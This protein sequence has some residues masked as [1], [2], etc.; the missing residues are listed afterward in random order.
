MYTQARVYSSYSSRVE[1]EWVV[2][3]WLLV[4]DGLSGPRRAVDIEAPVRYVSPFLVFYTTVVSPFADLP[5]WTRKRT[6]P[7]PENGISISLDR[8]LA[9]PKPLPVS[10][11]EC[12]QSFVLFC[13]VQMNL[14]TS[15]LV[16]LNRSSHD[17]WNIDRRDW[18][19]IIEFPIWRCWSRFENHFLT[20]FIFKEPL[21]L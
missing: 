9:H 19:V 5:L 7:R 12:T 10:S 8:L 20:K 17:A 16:L 6:R 13:F 18:L 1:R 15:T 11:R 4:S 2:D 21:C 3:Q 14:S